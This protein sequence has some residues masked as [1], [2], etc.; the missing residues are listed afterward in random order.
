MSPA[1]RRA[2]GLVLLAVVLAV[3]CGLLGRWQW[4]RHLARDAVIAVIEAGYGADPVPLADVLDSPGDAL[5]GD[6]VWRPVTVVG[7]YDAGAT[8]LLRNRP[9]N[10]QAGFHVLVPFVVTDPAQAGSAPLEAGDRPAVLV[11]DRGWIPTGESSER[12]D[13]LPAAPSGTVEITVRLRAD[14]PP[15]ARDAPDGEVQAISIDQVLAAGGRDPA[16]VDAYAAYG[17]LATEESAVPDDI[18]VLPK[19]ST[20]PGSHLSYAFQWWTF[21][22]GSLIGFSILARRELHEASAGDPTGR[23]ARPTGRRGKGPS[24]EEIEDALIDSQLG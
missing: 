1:A 3:T 6:E 10:S 22:L 13:T 11:V 15:S 16:D 9:I 8:A 20:D 4:N 24:A 19:P 14:E 23:P 7:H 12:P 17:A 18:G 5:A 21:A 2:A